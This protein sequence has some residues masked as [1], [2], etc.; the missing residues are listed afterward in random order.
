VS[1]QFAH[2][3]QKKHTKQLA[4]LYFCISYLYSFGFQTGNPN[5][6]HALPEFIV[7]VISS[8]MEFWFVRVVPT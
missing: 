5:I 1:D 4:K 2:P 8:W 3:P 6:L 7:L